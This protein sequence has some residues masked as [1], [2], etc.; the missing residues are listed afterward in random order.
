MTDIEKVENAVEKSANI[1]EVIEYCIPSLV[2]LLMI[3]WG[4]FFNDMDWTLIIVGLGLFLG[5][6]WYAYQAARGK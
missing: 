2:G 3:G 6:G 1:L 4:V 5:F